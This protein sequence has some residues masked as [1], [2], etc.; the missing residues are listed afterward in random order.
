MRSFKDFSSD[1]PRDV[2]KDQEISRLEIY[3][4]LKRDCKEQTTFLVERTI[5]RREACKDRN[6]FEI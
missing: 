5:D 1:D 3:R 6:F 4:R 2:C